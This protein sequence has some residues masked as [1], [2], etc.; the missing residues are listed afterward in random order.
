MLT[1]DTTHALVR[2]I[3]PRRISFAPY[4]PTPT[5]PTRFASLDG[6]RALAIA[7]VFVNHSAIAGRFSP[8]VTAVLESP[9]I[10]L[11]GLGVTTFFVVSGFL[12]TS[13]LLRELD[14]TGTI[15]ARRFFLRRSLRIFPAYF[16]FVTAVAALAWQGLVPVNPRSFAYALTFSTNYAGSSGSWTLGHLWSMASQE[17]FYLIWPLVLV[18]AGRRGATRVATAAVVITPIVHLL[19]ASLWPAA[20]KAHTFIFAFDTIAMG[21]LLALHR[22]QF[23][24][25]DW[26]NDLVASRIAIPLLFAIGLLGG[27]I[28]TRPGLLT[29]PLV[30]VAVAL[31]VERCIRYPSGALGRVLNSRP[32]VYVGTVSFSL[33]LWQ[34]LFVRPGT[35]TVPLVDVLAAVMIGLVSYNFV[36]QPAVALWP[37]VEQ[38]LAARRTNDARSFAPALDF[39]QWDTARAIS[40]ARRRIAMGG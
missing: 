7:T 12:I 34:Q 4:T 1:S 20:F 21:C 37:R 23:A 8:A 30:V 6:I 40:P 39:P 10:G 18:W 25:H 33:Y 17:Q 13:I 26:F 38:W 35:T 29:H 32:L 24:R 19:Y 15:D 28:G 16:V 36:E 3:R 9:F 22:E 14:R 5:A 11:Q 31:F 2:P 27:A